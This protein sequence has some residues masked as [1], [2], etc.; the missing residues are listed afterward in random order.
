MIGYYY[1]FYSKDEVGNIMYVNED[2]EFTYSLDFSMKFPSEK[3]ILNKIKI[4][5][6]NHADDEFSYMR[7]DY[8]IFNNCSIGMVETTLKEVILKL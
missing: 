7:K 4:S 1:V 2:E 6:E 3:E 5:N 8:N